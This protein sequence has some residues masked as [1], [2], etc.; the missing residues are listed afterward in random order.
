MTSFAA[1]AKIGVA[2]WRFSLLT[3][4]LLVMI[5]VAPLFGDDPAEEADVALIFSA[6]VL[7]V[8]AASQRTLL[9]GAA[10]TL[11]IALTWLK[12]LGSGATGEI[13][14]DAALI[15]LVFVAIESALRRALRARIV[16]RETIAA[17]LAAYL[18][19]GVGWAACFT[20]LE[21]A[22]PGAFALPADAADQSWSAL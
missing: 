13:A 16:D 4:A 18:L 17:A 10:C 15:L 2:R 14:A 6:V 20:L 3:L 22:A 19:L 12:P 7:G 21:T 9:A 8:A 1:E 5:A 11:W